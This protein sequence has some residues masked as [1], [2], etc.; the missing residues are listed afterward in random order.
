MD[1]LHFYMQNKAGI[2]FDFQIA[3]M[4]HSVQLGMLFILYTA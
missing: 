1:F 4:R 3:T 2:K